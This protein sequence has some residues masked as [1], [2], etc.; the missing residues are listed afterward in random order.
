MFRRKN[1]DGEWN[2]P[3]RRKGV[4]EK[5]IRHLR[6]SI[7][8]FFSFE[9]KSKVHIEPTYYTFSSYQNILIDKD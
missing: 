6:K 2:P 8:T 7:F 4:K 9:K 5:M 1:S 3:I